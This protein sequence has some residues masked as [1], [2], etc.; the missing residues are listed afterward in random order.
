MKKQNTKPAFR[1]LGVRLPEDLLREL[2]A[3]AR[4]RER[5]LSAEIRHLVR[6]E[7]EA[8]KKI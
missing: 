5:S 2:K 1:M 7:I 4:K 8:E 3:L 6:R